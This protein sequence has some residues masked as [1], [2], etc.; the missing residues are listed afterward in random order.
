MV[1]VGD[2][3]GLLAVRTDDEPGAVVGVGDD[4]RRGAGR[5]RRIGGGREIDA[6]WVPE[7]LGLPGAAA[8]AE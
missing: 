3:D 7:R 6:E 8:P 1:G 5:L 4:D 2:G